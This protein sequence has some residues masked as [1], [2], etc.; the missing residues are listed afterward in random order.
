MIEKKKREKI[1]MR[2]ILRTESRQV[3]FF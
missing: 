2:K 3:P 1:R